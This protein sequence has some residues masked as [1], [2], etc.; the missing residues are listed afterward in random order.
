MQSIQIMCLLDLLVVV[1]IYFDWLNTNETLWIN[2][3]TDA[4][5]KAFNAEF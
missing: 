4:A 2:N 1:S 5:I 3:H